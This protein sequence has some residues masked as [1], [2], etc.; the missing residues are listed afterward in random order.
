MTHPIHKAT[1][2]TLGLLLACI[3]GFS[4]PSVLAAIIEGND[5]RYGTDN[6]ITI[7]TAAGLEWL[8]WSITKQPYDVL[9]AQLVP[10]GT[11]EGWR[12][13]TDADVVT[14]LSD[15]RLPTGLGGEW[16]ARADPSLIKPLAQWGP[17]YETISYDRVAGTVKKVTW[18]NYEACF[19]DQK[20]VL[21]M[22][23]ADAAGIYVVATSR[24]TWQTGRT[25]GVYDG[26]ALVRDVHSVPEPSGLAMLS[27]VAPA[28]VRS[29]RR[30]SR[31]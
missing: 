16:T 23:G 18:T 8:D 10:G 21:V 3:S 7:D 9:Q 13:A 19:A 25:C 29:M 17:S 27:V 20:R 31:G 4:G 14:L 30:R 5:P 24:G 15:L 22:G 11:Y 6:N 26:W 1:R 12:L 28:L 2:Y